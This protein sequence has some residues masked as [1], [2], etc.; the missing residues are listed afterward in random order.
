[1][2]RN[3]MIHDSIGDLYWP[4]L[5]AINDYDLLYKYKWDFKDP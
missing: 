5:V 3:H 2:N 4:F 1:M